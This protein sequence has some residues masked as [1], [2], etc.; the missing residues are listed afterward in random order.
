MPSPDWRSDMTIEENSILAPIGEKEARLKNPLILAY[1]GDT[2]Y[3]MYVRTCLVKSFRYPVNIINKKASHIVNA[4]SQSEALEI[5][6]DIL[7]EDEAYIVKRGRNSSPQTTAKNSSRADY[8]RATGI[9]ALFG[10]LFLSGEYDRIE[11]LMDII[12][13]KMVDADE[14]Q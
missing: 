13:K 11:Y 6:K 9:E 2:V 10:Y 4:G 14:K 1:V 3:D 8:L 5:I 7:T 12:L